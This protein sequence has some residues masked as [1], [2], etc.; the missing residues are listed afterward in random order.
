MADLKYTEAIKKKKKK[1]QCR[2]SQLRKVGS[3]YITVP[4]SKKN[5]HLD[6]FYDW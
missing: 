3:S 1:K 5:L 6:A 4:I 2:K